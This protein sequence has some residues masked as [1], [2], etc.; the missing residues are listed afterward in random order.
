MT[1]T[2]RDLQQLDRRISALERDNQYF[3]DLIEKAVIQGR[4][5]AIILLI[6]SL[7]LGAWKWLPLFLPA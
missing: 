2:E 3:F 7:V 1:Q 4:R 6:I 5:I